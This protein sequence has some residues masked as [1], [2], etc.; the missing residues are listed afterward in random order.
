MCVVLSYYERKVVHVNDF[1]YYAKLNRCCTF[2]LLRSIDCAF[3]I[4]YSILHCVKPIVA[5]KMR[6]VVV[7]KYTNINIA[8]YRVW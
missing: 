3:N 4:L 5:I 7:I 8:G 1:K 6:G 2:S